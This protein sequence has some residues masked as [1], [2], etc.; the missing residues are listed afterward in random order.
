MLQWCDLPKALAE[1]ARVLRPGGQLCFAT[2]LKGTLRE[3]DAA[4]ASADTH[5]HT[6]GISRFEREV[7][8]AL[9][10]AGLLK[11]GCTTARRVEYFPDARSLLQSNRDIGASRVPDRGR[12]GVLGRAR[13]TR[14][15]AVW[16]RREAVQVFR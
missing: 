7:T 12:R 11:Q 13:G 1:C 5:R 16:S 14:C 15:V 3:I 9:A 6:R 4:F 10:S 8:D 2:V